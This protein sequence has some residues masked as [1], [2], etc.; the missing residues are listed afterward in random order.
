MKNLGR[1]D[2]TSEDAGNFEWNTGLKSSIKCTK[3]MMMVWEL[4]L[5]IS[6]PMAKEQRDQPIL[7][8]NG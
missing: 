7:S 2:C 6:I 4:V 1:E 8:N 5:V 3:H